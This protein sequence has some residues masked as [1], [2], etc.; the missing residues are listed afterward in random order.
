M[1]FLSMPI[2]LHRSEGF[3]HLI[4]AKYSAGMMPISN[5]NVDHEPRLLFER[6]SAE[7]VDANVDVDEKAA[8]EARC[9]G[10]AL[11]NKEM[12]VW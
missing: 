11:L 12:T 5:V 7:I 6:K 10:A 4:A 2:A 9:E 8:V 3:R 1:A